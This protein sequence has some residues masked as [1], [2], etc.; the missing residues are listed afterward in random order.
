M[1]CINLSERLTSPGLIAVLDRWVGSITRP[2]K[3]LPVLAADDLSVSVKWHQT[4]PWTRFGVFQK[5][6]KIPIYICYTKDWGLDKWGLV[7]QKTQHLRYKKRREGCWCC[8]MWGVP[9]ENYRQRRQWQG[10]SSHSRLM[11]APGRLPRVHPMDTPQTFRSCGL[12]HHRWQQQLLICVGFWT[13]LASTTVSG[14][15]FLFVIVVD[16]SKL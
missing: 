8:V 1:I 7:Q 6:I 16:G 2:R 11:T 12:V 14:C 13:A 4:P 10:S 15:F 3:S 5:S 9:L